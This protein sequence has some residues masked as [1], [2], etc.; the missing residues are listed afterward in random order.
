MKIDF[1][2]VQGGYWKEVLLIELNWSS[3]KPF[4]D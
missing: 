3:M 2:N 1:S 4:F